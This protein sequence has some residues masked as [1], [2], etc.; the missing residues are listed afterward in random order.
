MLFRI[1]P[2]PYQLEVNTLEAQLASMQGS[3][4]ELEE[5]RR[6]RR[7]KVDG[8][9]AQSR[10]RASIARR[11]RSTWRASASSSTASWSTTGA[12][13]RFDLERAET[14]V[15]EQQGQLDAARSA[16]AQARAGAG[17]A[18]SRSQQKLGATVNGEFAQ[19]AQ[20]RA[21]LENAQVGARADHHALALRL[22]RGQ[23]AA[24][25]RADSSPACRSTR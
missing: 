1:D 21:Q 24:A 9:A 4:R 10:R 12:G 8:V 23:P 3:Q 2:T 20:I 22:L 16:E 7:R 17:L 11:A 15:L 25:A 13:N 14:D 18:S 19:V 6:A 5:R